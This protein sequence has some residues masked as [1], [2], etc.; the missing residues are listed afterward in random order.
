MYALS[1]MINLGL[2]EGQDWPSPEYKMVASVIGLRN[3][4]VTNRD[5]LIDIVQ[6]VLKVSQERIKSITPD[7]LYEEFGCPQVW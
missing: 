1:E 6:S 2:K 4:N 7:Q 3:R 5:C